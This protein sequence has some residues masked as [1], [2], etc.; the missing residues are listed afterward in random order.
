MRLSYGTGAAIRMTMA[1]CSGEIAVLP[2]DEEYEE[3]EEL[4]GS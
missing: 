2:R 3:M 1:G 4:C